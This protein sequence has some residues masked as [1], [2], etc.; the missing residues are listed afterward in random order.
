MTASCAATDSDC[1][2][3]KITM[4]DRVYRAP[5][6]RFADLLATSLRSLAEL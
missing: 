3:F 2:S 4:L 1:W 6:L 5:K